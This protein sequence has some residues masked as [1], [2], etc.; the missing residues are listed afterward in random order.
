MSGIRKESAIVYRG[1]GRRWFTLDAACRA[2]ARAKLK[3]RCEC[4]SGDA[5]AQ[6]PGST[7]H[8][9]GE[10]YGRF[11]RKLAAIYKAAQQEP[12]P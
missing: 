3:T 10:R 2:A 7:C 11:V 4:D 5:E 1:G 12:T 8:Y 6:Y 9:H